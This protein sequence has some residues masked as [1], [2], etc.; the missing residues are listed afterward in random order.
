[1][2]MKRRDVLVEHLGERIA[3]LGEDV[4]LFSPGP[5]SP[6]GAANAFCDARAS[7]RRTLAPSGIYHA[8][9]R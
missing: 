3:E 6:D 4:V 9:S 5:G 8:C 2:L 1:M 7:S